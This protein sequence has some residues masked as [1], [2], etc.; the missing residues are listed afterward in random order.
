MDNSTI[1]QG[2]KLTTI[3][4]HNRTENIG[5]DVWSEFVI[6]RYYDQYDFFGTMPCVIQGGRGCGKTMLLRFLSYKSQF[7]LTRNYKENFDSKLLDNIG[8]YLRSDTA[9]LRQLNKRGLEDHVWQS[10]FT[11][12][13]AVKISIEIIE[14]VL[15]IND[16]LNLFPANNVK[17]EQLIDFDPRFNT[18]IRSLKSELEKMRREF[19]IAASNPSKI[20]KIS[21]IPHSF[22]K[23]LI[24][25]L[26]DK[27]SHFEKSNFHVF[28]DEYENLLP[29]QQILINTS[30][31]HSEPP[32]I[33]KIA[34]K[35][36]GM[37]IKETVGDES[38]QE[39]DDYIVHDIDDYTMENDYNV[40]AGEVLLSR[41]SSVEKQNLDIQL[42]DFSKLNDRRKSNYTSDIL[43]TVKSILPGKTQQELAHDVFEIRSLRSKLE[44]LIRQALEAKREVELQ[45]NDFVYEQ[46]KEASI[47]CSA[48]LN[49]AS[50]SP[51]ILNAELLKHLNGESTRFQDWIGTNFVGSYINIIKRR[52][53]ENRLY[54]GYDT[55]ISLSK[56]NLRH[57]LELSRTAFS[58]GYEYKDGKFSISLENQLYAAEKTSNALFNE[59]KS[60]KPSGSKL[61]LFVHRLGNVFALY[62]NRLSQSEPE[63]AH[64][65]IEGGD[66]A[67]SENART[68]LHECEKWG[69]LYKTPATKTK[70]KLEIDDYDWVLNP[71]YSPQFLISYRK[72]RKITIGSNE[73]DFL[74]SD[75]NKPYQEYYAAIASKIK[76]KNAGAFTEE[77]PQKGL[78][79]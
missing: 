22:I 47:V 4:A 48:L 58:L 60:F 25:S 6:P 30:I 9:F 11:H 50:T 69:I 42:N 63:I 44:D 36:N 5:E 76:D 39:K 59:I 46:A 71:I 2:K 34:C 78:F 45:I 41:I 77:Y 40:F 27:C 43:Q 57:F 70:S 61:H 53:Q 31:K 49:R 37:P 24:L 17:L 29:Y 14:S 72:K 26:K 21:F 3:L 52:R 51:K 18:D 54:C 7:S 68:L 1:E 64:F 35:R 74:F 12:Y 13:I 10:S 33:Y 67:L 19:D 8:L 65:S 32:L 15:Q 55:Y 66:T 20:E 28:I 23:E 75:D 79:E 56:G 38:I 16:K 62:Q 73:L